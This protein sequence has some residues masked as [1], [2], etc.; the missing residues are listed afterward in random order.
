MIT[1]PSV[2]TTQKQETSETN[3]ILDTFQQTFVKIEK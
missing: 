3:P 2:N 1:L